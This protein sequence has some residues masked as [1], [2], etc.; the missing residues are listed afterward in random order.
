MS[1]LIK[2]RID[3]TSN[4][5][6]LSLSL[7]VAALGLVLVFPISMYCEEQTVIT[8]CELFKDLR[9]NSGKIIKVRGEIRPTLHSFALG[10]SACSNAS[11]PPAQDN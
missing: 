1:P 11:S 8:G 10:E 5:R 7:R 2:H 3:F 6:T 4:L 9:A